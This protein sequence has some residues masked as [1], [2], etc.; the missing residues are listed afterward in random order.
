MLLLFSQCPKRPGSE[1]RDY[2]FGSLSDFC[3]VMPKSVTLAAT[4]QCYLVLNALNPINLCALNIDLS[5]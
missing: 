2:R 4:R 1:F 3:L 5:L